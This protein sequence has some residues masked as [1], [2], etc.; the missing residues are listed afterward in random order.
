MG[1]YQAALFLFPKAGLT[2]AEKAIAFGPDRSNLI[3]RRFD[4]PS[5]VPAMLS[6]ER[7]RENLLEG[8]LLPRRLY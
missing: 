6:R 1:R 3:V 8:M 5:P 4:P 7:A 2:S